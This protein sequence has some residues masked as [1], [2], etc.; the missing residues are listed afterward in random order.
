MEL[1]LA[2]KAHPQ[3]VKSVGLYKVVG[4]AVVGGIYH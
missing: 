2:L 3:V 4:E 1:G